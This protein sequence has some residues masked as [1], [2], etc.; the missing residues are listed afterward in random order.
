MTKKEW[1]FAAIFTLITILAWVISDIIHARSKVE[2]PPKMQEIMEP[3]N[4]NFN[5]ENLD[6]EP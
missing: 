3:I 2:I 6:V 5:I 1:L 4:P